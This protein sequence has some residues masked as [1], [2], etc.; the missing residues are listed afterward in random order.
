MKG[1]TERNG[2]YR[3]T[4]SLGYDQNGKQIRKTTT[5]KPDDTLT[6]AKRL[7]AVESAYIEFKQRVLSL[8][9]LNENIRFK[10]LF[11]SYMSLYAKNELKDIT[12]Y[13]YEHLCNYHLMPFLAN[14]KVKDVKT[15]FLTSF[16][17]NM[18][19][20]ATTARKLYVICSS[21]FSFAV[22]QGYIKDNP[23]KNVILPKQEKTDKR[24]S[25]TEE[26]IPE[27]LKLFEGYSVLNTAVKVLLCT[28]MRSGELL[29]LRWSDIDFNNSTISIN[30]T[31]SDVGGKHFIT[32]PKTAT[33][34]RIIGMN[35]SVKG[36]LLEHR[37]HQRE[38]ENI[39]KNG[40]FDMVFT[41]ET[42]NYKDRSNLNTSFKRRL[43]G[44]EFEFM[45][46]H[47]LRHS[48]ATF[49]LNTG[50]DLKIVSEHLGHSDVSVTAMIYTD[51]LE[52]TKRKTAQI[53]DFVMKYDEINTKQT[54]KH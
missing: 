28:G 23:C 49:L 34:K 19:V 33:S 9:T 40:H 38:L 11:D 36:L 32:A 1:I 6:P 17:N 20:S 7:K 27:F 53:L 15:P 2:S 3:F 39:C 51:V 31:L 10:E 42:G 37:E 47:K 13:N 46:L 50:V 21:V 52:S 14:K 12:A 5:Y 43:K 30:G 41:S 44:T 16:F 45:T 18:S 22:K 48:T 35:D 8:N 29:A 26:E 24:K 25:L 4:V 54:P